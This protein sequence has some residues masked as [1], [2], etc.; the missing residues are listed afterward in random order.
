MTRRRALQIVAGSIATP[1]ILSRTA[2]SKTVPGGLL[3]IGCIG[4]G[5]M[6]RG[7]MQNAIYRGLSEAT[8]ARVVAVCDLDADRARLAAERVESI[9]RDELAG[10]GVER[11][12]VH[13]RFR[14]E[15]LYANGVKLISSSGD[16]GVKFV[17]DEG[18]IWVER[19]SMKPHDPKLLRERIRDDEVRLYESRDHMSNFLEC[20]RNGTEPICPV[21][22]GHRS[23]TVCVLHH[24]AMKLGRKLAWN[25]ETEAFTDN[26][27]ANALLDY[28]HRKPWL[29]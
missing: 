14:G 19:G 27:D 23:N 18:W 16:A 28:P 22:V 11:V 15:A 2:Y 7:D 26:S 21:K 20:A 24:I 9:Y 29:L 8:P 4:T 5:R 25:P 1:T 12:G 17:G 3:R 6:G 13:T 10:S